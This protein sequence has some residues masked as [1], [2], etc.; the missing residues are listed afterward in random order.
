MSILFCNI[1]WMELYR[2]QQGGEEISGGGAWVEEHEHGS[3]V[4]NF[5]DHEGTMYGYVQ[6]P[7]K[8]I[9]L[10]RIARNG[11]GQLAEQNPVSIDG[12]LIVWTAPAPQGGS[13]VVGWYKDATVYR[14][15]QKFDDAPPI[16]GGS[17]VGG[18]R[19]TVKSVNAVLLPVD[20][21]TFRNPRGKKGMM[22]QANIWYADTP[23]S[24]PVV[25]DVRAL[26]GGMLR[27][28]PGRKGQT[29]PEH[30]AKVEKAAVQVVRK[31][32]SRLGYVV[33]SV[34][35]DNVG[36]DLEANFEDKVCLRIEV[37]GL[38]GPEPRVGLTPNEY[39]KFM[40]NADDYRLAIVTCAIS[41]SP[42][43]RVCRFSAGQEKW[44]IDGQDGCEIAIEPRTSAI[45]RVSMEACP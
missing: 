39:D 5:V 14:A 22:G 18:Y 1:G 37:K 40:E 21:R 34:E 44:I 31:Y 32:Y 12:V 16:H 17:R 36:W 33:E 27:R 38:S 13:F 35:T 43:L 30:N 45:V 25:H 26:V 41:D 20:A 9:D 24:E 10:E 19:F 11:M 23:E 29:D 3:E 8:N 6:P 7:G 42:E 28:V 15:Y 4:C 2:G